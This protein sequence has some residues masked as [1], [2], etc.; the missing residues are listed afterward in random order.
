MLIFLLQLCCFSLSNDIHEFQPVYCMLT[1]ATIYHAH[2]F[3]TWV[4]YTLYSL[5]GPT[6]LPSYVL[7][8]CPN[9]PLS[10]CPTVLL[11]CCLTVPLSYCP[12]VLLSCCPTVLLSYCPT[13][14]LSYCPI[15]LLSYC[16]TILLSHCPTVLLSYC[17]TVLLSHCPTVLLSHCLTVLLSYC[18]TV[19]LSYRIA[20]TYRI[21]WQYISPDYYY[22]VMYLPIPWQSQI[23]FYKTWR[24]GPQEHLEKNWEKLKCSFFR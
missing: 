19:P 10:Y 8:Y 4:S 5:T 21:A 13:V 1:S 16:P 3:S 20:W 22:I 2:T 17:S 11:S 6:V 12:T 18:P 23:Y 7:S 24:K 15:A 14:S 9:V